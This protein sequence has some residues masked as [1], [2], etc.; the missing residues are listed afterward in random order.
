M[1]KLIAKI[2][3][4]FLKQRR[5]YEASLLPHDYYFS[6]LTTLLTTYFTLYSLLKGTLPSLFPSI[7]HEY[8]ISPTH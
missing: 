1:T 6:L 3:E 8:F 4:T 7:L 2:C 5:T